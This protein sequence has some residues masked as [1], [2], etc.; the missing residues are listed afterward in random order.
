MEKYLALL[1]SQTAIVL[2]LSNPSNK[3]PGQDTKRLR[4]NLYREWVDVR[5]R[6]SSAESLL[7]PN[8]DSLP[9]GQS[10]EEDGNMVSLTRA[11]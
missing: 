3:S 10:H 8:D 6:H 5:S 4:L 7:N 1:I 2:L 11:S 9:S